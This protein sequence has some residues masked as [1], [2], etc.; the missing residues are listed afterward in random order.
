MKKITLK[1]SAFLLLAMSAFQVNAQNCPEL[2]IDPGVYKLAT[3]GV[4][5]SELFITIN[6]SSGQLEW[7]DEITTAP[8]EATQLWTVQDHVMPAGS[9]FVQLTADLSA[10]SAGPWTMIVDQSSYDGPGD[11]DG[12]VT[13]TARMGDP[14]ADTMDPNYEFDQFQRRKAT[15]WTGAG[16]N[17]L[18]A[19]PP[20]Q[21]NFRYS[22]AP[23]AAGDPVVFNDG[24]T[25][26]DIRYIF[27]EPLSTEEFDTSSVFI[28]N[29]VKDELSI[30]GLNQSIK[31]ISIYDL[32]GKQVISRN[33]SED[34]TSTNL[35]VSSLNTGLYIV[36]L[37]GENGASLTKKIVKQ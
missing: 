36:K 35:D 8:A 22:V 27:V 34:T 31:Q 20:G 32:L 2:F 24:G 33:F 9:G 19:K 17:A 13:I 10:L 28:S 18:F 4:S 29:P 30:E 26:N 21:G 15:G 23:A 5:G 3:C 25:I 12:V 37:E 16:N 6:G 7:A 1:I 11:S 14:I